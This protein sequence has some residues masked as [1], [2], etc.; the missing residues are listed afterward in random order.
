MSAYIKSH[1]F[2]TISSVFFFLNKI[3]PTVNN[4]PH[5]ITHIKTINIVT[6][7][8][9]SIKR[10]VTLNTHNANEKNTSTKKIFLHSP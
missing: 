6:S 7:M 5:C 4:A 2:Y 9:L 8:S 3:F 10:K 1:N